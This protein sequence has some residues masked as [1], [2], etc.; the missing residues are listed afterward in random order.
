MKKYFVFIISILCVFMIFS[1]GCKQRLTTPDGEDYT[2]YRTKTYTSVEFFGTATYVVLGGDTGDKNVVSKMNSTWEKIKERLREIDYALNESNAESDVARFN[3]ADEGARIKVSEHTYYL[4][5]LCQSLKTL[6][7]GKF[8]PTTAHLVDLWGF[9]PRFSGDYRQTQPYDRSDYKNSLPQ[10]KYID[11][12]KSL[13]GVEKIVCER[14]GNECYL[15]KPDVRAVVDGVEYTMAISLGGIGKGYAC[16]VVYDIVRE[17]GFNFGYV[18][19]GSS[20]LA[21]MNALRP[22]E[23]DYPLAWRVGIVNPRDEGNYLSVLA[24]EQGFSTSGDYERYYEIDG[25]RYCHIIDTSDG[26]PAD[27]GIITASVAGNSAAICD[28]LSTAIC[29]MTPEQA[30]EFAQSISERVYFAYASGDKYLVYVANGA[31]PI[32]ENG[33]FELV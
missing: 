21:L 11:A 20:S 19:V 7:M 3:A 27:G 8:D 25:K 22:D 13:V 33:E 6:T 5:E 14:Q 32:I 15:V 24:L 30:A 9:S 4:V 2:D 31:K 26:C 16:D 17:N 1:S 18:N 23:E 10:Q 28:A 29:C 12:F